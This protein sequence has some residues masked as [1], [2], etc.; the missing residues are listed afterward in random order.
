MYKNSIRTRPL[1]R[2]ISNHAKGKFALD[3]AYKLKCGLEIHTQLNTRYKLFSYTSNEAENLTI[4]P[5]TSTSHY[6]ISL[7]GTQPRLNYEAVLYATKLALS[8]DSDINLVS[9]FDRK[10]YFYG[11][12]PQG[13][14]VTQHYKPFAKNGKLTLYGAYEDINENEKT[15]RI[16]QLQIEQD[17]GKS[18]YASGADMTTMIDLNRSNVPLIELVTKPDF[19]DLKQVRAFIKK[20]QDLVRRLNICTGNLETGS[21]RI[22]VNLSV[23]DFAR[24]ELKN[25]PN[26]SSIM[27]AIKFEYER[28]LHIIKNGDG[29]RLLRDT[30]TRGWT[31][32]ETVKLRSKETSIDYRYMPDPEIPFIT[33]AD[34]VVHKVKSTLPVSA[35]ALLREFMNKPYNLPIKH[36]K[37]L[38]ISG[39]QNEMYDHEQLRKYY[40]DVCVHYQKEYPDDNLKIPSNWILNEFIGN[41]NKLETKLNEI[42]EILTPSIFF[43]LI[44]L[45]KQGVITGNS[46][47]LLLFHIVN[48]VKTGVFT[49][50]SQINLK[51]LINEYE[52]QAADQI[53][54]HEL[55][56][57]CRSIID[58]I[59]DEKLLQNLIS[60]KKKT[61][62]KFL[63]GQGMRLSQGRLNPNELEKMFRQVLDIKW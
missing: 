32:S 44:R 20:Y 22:D 43:E 54:E 51:Q 41:L 47:K 62:L 17:T 39:N 38:C 56:E 48:N 9:Q 40:K 10:H 46:S 19:E 61:S 12:Q 34:D 53:N 13:Y 15:I 30:E 3:P 60:G 11:D 5:N 23:N 31:G 29:E 33:I 27:N 52:L 21:M 55:E 25:L 8:L 6:D 58:D 59:K 45:M 28:Q 36:A 26:T 16:E 18:L 2:F 14:Q 50:S 35:D 37:I 1:K 42:Y 4:S 7:P 49:K 57:I 24:V 63:V